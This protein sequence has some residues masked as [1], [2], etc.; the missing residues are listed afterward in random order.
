M[1]K[2]RETK[3]GRR[4]G[5][6]SRLFGND[7]LG[8]LFS[9]IHATS[10]RAG[11]ELEH[12]IESKANVLEDVDG[13]VS[14]SL[15]NGTYLITKKVMKKHPVL[16]GSKEPDFLIV[17]ITKNR[18]LI[19][20]VK[21]GDTFDTKKAAGE[22]KHLME[23]QTHLS[24]KIPYTTNIYV[25]CFNQENKQVIVDGFKGEFSINEVMTGSEFCNLL[26]IN[27]DDI[28]TIRKNHQRDNVIYLKEKF[29]ELSI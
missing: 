16:K 21:D 12:L 24:T 28:L 20:E 25:C 19:I 27:K 17:K 13:F 23:Y 9:Q 29:A 14:G 8:A 15:P 3:E 2:I 7:D 1:A 18:C 22:R 26:N 4:D 11:T 5:G 6:Y 10:I